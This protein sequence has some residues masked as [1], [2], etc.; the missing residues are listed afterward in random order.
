MQNV[1]IVDIIIAK[2]VVISV[3]LLLYAPRMVYHMR[4]NQ[5]W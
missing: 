5:S 2:S 1:R 3:M 4:S